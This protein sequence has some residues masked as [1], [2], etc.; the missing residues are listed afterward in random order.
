MELERHG[1]IGSVV[2]SGFGT[3][4]GEI[5]SEKCAEQMALAVRHFEEA[6]AN[7]AKWSHLGPG[8]VYA[9]DEE[10]AATRYT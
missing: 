8:E 6:C 10:I 3:G 9:L 4:V 1:G 2:M 5:S 7:E